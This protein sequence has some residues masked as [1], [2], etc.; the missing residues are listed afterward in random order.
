MRAHQGDPGGLHRASDVARLLDRQAE[1]LLAQDVHPGGRR[2]DDG[3]R[4]EVMGQA[5]VDGVDHRVGQ[6]VAVVEVDPGAT[7]PLGHRPGVLGID[8]GDGRDG[9]GLGLGEITEQV[10]A[11]DRSAAD[12]ADPDRGG[13]AHG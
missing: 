6:H 2:S 13:S 9:D 8:V 1:R 3:V 7:G 12:D 10:L 4:V 11:R 5:D